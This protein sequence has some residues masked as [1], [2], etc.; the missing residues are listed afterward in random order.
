MIFKILRSIN[1]MRLIA[2]R[3]D[4]LWD[5]WW[6]NATI[7]RIKLGWF[8]FWNSIYWLWQVQY[9]HRHPCHNLPRDYW[10]IK[11]IRPVC[12][13]PKDH[14]LTH[15]RISFRIETLWSNKYKNTSQQ[16]T[17]E[18]ELDELEVYFSSMKNK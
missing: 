5:N 13:R 10:G 17:K 1:P 12:I 18:V 16:S 3:D 2:P 4:S 14:F 8:Y 6:K 9:H 11:S 15:P 7:N